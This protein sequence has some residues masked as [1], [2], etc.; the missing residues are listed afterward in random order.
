MLVR[1]LECKVNTLIFLESPELP[2]EFI[3]FYLIQMLKVLADERQRHLRR[4]ID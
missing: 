1:C 4:K 2:R 3:S